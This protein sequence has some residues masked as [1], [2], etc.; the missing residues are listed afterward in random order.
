MKI[1]FIYPDVI[2]SA[3]YT[4]I[5][6]LGIGLLSSVLKNNGFNTSLIH[7]SQPIGKNDFIKYL[8]KENA[9]VY[10]F[11]TTTPMFS[12]VQEWAGW[13]KEH[14]QKKI[15]VVGGAHAILNP[16][17]IFK[18]LAVD[19]VCTGE[20]EYS[21]LE[22]CVALK[23]KQPVNNIS[24]IW[25][26][27]GDK[28]IKTPQRLLT[29]DLDQLLFADRTIFKHKQLMEGKEQMFFVMASRGCPY[30]CPYCCNQ[31]IRQNVAGQ[32]P[33]VRFRSVDNVIAEI[34]AVLKLYPQT[35]F[36]GFY[37]DILALKK[38][39][40]AEFTEKYKTQIKLPF[41]CNMRANYLAQE[42]TT[43]MLYEAG[44]CRVII[45][46]E[47]GNEALRNGVLQRNM[48][49][50]IILEAAGLC[51]NIILNSRLLIWSD[52]PGKGQKK[53]WIQ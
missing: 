34:Q 28:I 51:K 52:Y 45:G 41:R 40:F 22:L 27:Q 50:Q 30:N 18:T 14:N 44:C 5:Y 26:R 39:W 33:W 42:E 32:Q 38:D 8:E 10:A 1:A 19:F 16:E 17:E 9:D 12:F 4:G 23:Q 48:P 2:G 36:I 24:G 35:K 49:D 53:S 3:N 31:S 46:L 20:G 7:I 11:S 15:I 25:S 6:N 47:S 13:I 21:L 37:D 43:K 29:T